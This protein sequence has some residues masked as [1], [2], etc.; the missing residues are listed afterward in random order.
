MLPLIT[1]P[2]LLSGC[3]AASADLAG[4]AFGVLA[5]AAL[6][7]VGSKSGRARYR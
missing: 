6:I 7:A 3:D 1:I 2:A 5:L 4:V